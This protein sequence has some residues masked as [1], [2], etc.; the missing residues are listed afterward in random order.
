MSMSTIAEPHLFIAELIAGIPTAILTTIDD[1]EHMESRPMAT[2]DYKFE[3]SIWF[4]ASRSSRLVPHLIHN[5]HVNVS[6]CH[7]GGKTFVS[8]SGNSEIVD[9]A[10]LIRQ[11][12]RPLFSTWFEHGSQDPDL[13]LIRVNAVSADCWEHQPTPFHL[14]P[15][16]QPPWVDGGSPMHGIYRRITW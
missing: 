3:G 13:T 10:V 7:P 8:L 2:L 11:L 9:D 5:P 14:P 12:W 16:A 4:L 15:G 6:Y 1:H